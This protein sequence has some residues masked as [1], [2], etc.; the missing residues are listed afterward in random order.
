MNSKHRRPLQEGQG[1]I[2][3]HLVDSKKQILSLRVKK[4]LDFKEK[5]KETIDIRVSTIDRA[6]L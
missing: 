2:D 5:T 3:S 1:H 6:I 4:W